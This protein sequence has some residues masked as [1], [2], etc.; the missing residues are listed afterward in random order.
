MG[1]P[2][3]GPAN[4][5]SDNAAVVNNASRS[6][7]GLKKKSLAM[8]YHMIR[9]ANASGMIRIAWESVN[10]NIADI[11]TK[12]LSGTRLQYLYGKFMK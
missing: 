1:F 2:I 10:E 11:L 4:I 9:E 6:E 3:D 5:F 7:S 8:C 12:F